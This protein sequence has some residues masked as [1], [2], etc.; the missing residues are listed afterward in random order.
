MKARLSYIAESKLPLAFDLFPLV[1]DR[2]KNWKNKQELTDYIDSLYFKPEYVY[3]Y[4]KCQCG[5]EF[6]Y[7]DKTSVPASNLNCSCKRKI[8]LYSN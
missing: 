8:F 6:V 5:K 1:R 2:N 7:Q 3:L 4:C